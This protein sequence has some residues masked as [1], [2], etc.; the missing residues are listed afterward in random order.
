MP[1]GGEFIVNLD[2]IYTDSQGYAYTDI[3]LGGGGGGRLKFSAGQLR[4]TVL[5]MASMGNFI[6]Q[7]ICTPAIWNCG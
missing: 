1:D 5:L 2:D 7:K 6:H 3:D 4:L